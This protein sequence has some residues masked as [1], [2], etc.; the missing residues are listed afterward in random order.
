MRVRNVS[1]W[2]R[3]SVNAPESKVGKPITLVSCS[4][5]CLSSACAHS[6]WRTSRPSP[7][8]E[9]Q[10]ETTDKRRASCFPEAHQDYW[11]DSER[12]HTFG[13]A[14]SSTRALRSSNRPPSSETSSPG[15][16]GR[17]RRL[18]HDDLAFDNDR[19]VR[20]LGDEREDGNA[21]ERRQGDRIP[22]SRRRLGG[23]ACSVGSADEGEEQGPLGRTVRELEDELSAGARPALV[24]LPDIVVLTGCRVV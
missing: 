19:L 13:P 20:D 6:T 5:P 7:R 16:R 11:L 15:A 10:A 17:R 8:K 2:V 23:A 21:E 14:S 9:R 4:G 1:D 24:R 22:E 3:H 18:A 12:P